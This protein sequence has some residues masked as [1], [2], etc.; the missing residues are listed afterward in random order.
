MS[1]WSFFSSSST[2]INLHKSEV[3]QHSLVL[4]ILDQQSGF[5]L[6]L[7]HCCNSQLLLQQRNLL[8]DEDVCLSRDWPLPGQSGLDDIM[9]PEAGRAG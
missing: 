4:L 1:E 5:T 7:P 8:M 2:A 3:R 9:L 6:V